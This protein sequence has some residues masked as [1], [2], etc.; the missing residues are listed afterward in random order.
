MGKILSIVFLVSASMT[1]LLTGCNSG[2]CTELRSSVP[3]ATFYSSSSQ[4]PLTIDSLEIIGIGA[5]GDSTLYDASDRLTNI[6]LPMP[7]ET[8]RVQWRFSY[9]QV[10]LAQ[11]EIADTIT[12]DFNRTP[13]FAGEECGAMYKY[14]ISAVDYTTNVIDSVV[15][16]DSLVTNIESTNLKI[17]FRTAQ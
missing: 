13:W 15:L 8:D 6:Y 5:P 2:G 7:P 1:L 3:R 4:T 12:L 16:A 10:S 14:N 17:Y 11:F 9:K